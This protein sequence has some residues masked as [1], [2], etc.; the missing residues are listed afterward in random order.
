MKVF[1]MPIETFLRDY[2]PIIAFAIGGLIWG[3]RMEGQV[4]KANT[5]VRALWKQREE[6]QRDDEKSRGEVHELLTELRHDVKQLLA[7]GSK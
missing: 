6:D 7:Q 5:G 3:L 4:S 1:L 2:W